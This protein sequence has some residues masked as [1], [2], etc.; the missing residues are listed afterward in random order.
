MDFLK[1]VL[2]LPMRNWN[3]ETCHPGLDFVLCF[4]P[5]YEELK[6]ARAFYIT[7]VFECFEPTYEELKPSPPL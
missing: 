3:V 1:Y 6:P 2:S 5:T 7:P 4:E